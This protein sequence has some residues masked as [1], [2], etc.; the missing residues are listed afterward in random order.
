MYLTPQGRLLSQHSWPCKA[1]DSSSQGGWWGWG[2][3]GWAALSSLQ[4]EEQG[5]GTRIKGSYNSVSG[6]SCKC[7]QRDEVLPPGALR[8]P[9]VAGPKGTGCLGHGGHLLPNSSKGLGI[10]FVAVR[11]CTPTLAW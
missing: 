8:G 10:A 2:G 7:R 11:T 1:A 9:Q 4:R 6:R 3:K 5:P